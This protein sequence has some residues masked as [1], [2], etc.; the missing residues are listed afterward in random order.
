MRKVILLEHISLDGF[1]AGPQGEMD[2]IYIDDEMFEVVGE[3]TDSADTALYGRVT[4]EMME[5]YWPTAGEQPGASKHDIQ[6]SNWVNNATKIV[7]SRTLKETNWNNTRIISE[8]IDEEIRRLKDQEGENMLMIGSPGIA[9][10][11]MKLKLIDEY[12]LY[13]NPVILG[14]GIRLFNNGH[15]RTNLKLIESKNFEAG[16]VGLHFSAET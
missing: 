10:T 8:N 15:D 9:Q 3:L 1:V 2:W 14:N 11:F 5:S 12:W 7:F 6:H 4:Y 13:L 16:V